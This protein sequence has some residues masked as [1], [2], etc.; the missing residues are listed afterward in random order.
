MNSKMLPNIMKKISASFISTN[1]NKMS[2]CDGTNLYTIIF[3]N[4]AL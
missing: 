3:H 4:S 2:G 1:S